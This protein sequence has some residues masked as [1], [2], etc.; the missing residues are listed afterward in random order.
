MLLKQETHQLTPWWSDIS[1]LFWRTWDVYTDA[2]MVYDE[3]RDQDDYDTVMEI[4]NLFGR[5]STLLR[6]AMQY[7][8][9]CTCKPTGG[10][11][12]V[13]SLAEDAAYLEKE[14]SY[15]EE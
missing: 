7:R 9:E 15:Y 10:V 12:T 2:V 14:V 1:N 8:G 13:C 3:S 6:D 5:V 11:C 4:G